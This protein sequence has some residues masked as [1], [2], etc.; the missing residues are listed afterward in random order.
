MSVTCMSVTY[1]SVAWDKTISSC[2]A[3]AFA[4]VCAAAASVPAA[5]QDGATGFFKDKTITLE[6]GAAP[7]GVLDLHAR[8]VSRYLGRH[9]PGNP[10]VRVAYKPGAGSK[11][12]ARG[13]YTTAPKDGTWI[14]ATFPSA[15]VDPLLE[16][17][18]LDYDPTK[19]QYVGS[20][21]VEVPICMVRADGP[22]KTLQDLMTKELIISATGPGGTNHD[23]PAAM[24]GL[25]GAKFKLVKGYPGGAQLGLAIERNEVQGIC[26][27]WSYTKV[28]YPD[29]LN[30]TLFAK[31][32]VQGSMTG[33]PDLTKAG[34]PLAVSLAKNE[35][36]RQ[37]MELFLARYAFA[38][39]YMLPPGVP[40]DRVRALR[41]AF[42]AMMAD[43]ELI[44]EARRTSTDIKLT[45]GE[46]VQTLVNR[47]YQSPKPVVDHLRDALLGKP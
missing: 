30:G 36:D 21:A 18:G 8:L 19:F 3:W 13:L 31:I 7:G 22:I 33:D 5:A 2:N 12:V 1:M 47:I 16:I 26:G 4:V 20:G 25:L 23:F 24:A 6:V 14:G 40:D 28:Q 41:N 43:P 42:A 9:V 27:S 34:V 10:N 17:T 44:A 32:F 37:A 29:I 38:T 39:P 11:V 46:D 35:P 45:T 15:I